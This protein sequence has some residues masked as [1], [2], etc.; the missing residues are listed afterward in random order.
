MIPRQTD[1]L[2]GTETKCDN[3]CKHLLRII[4][5]ALNEKNCNMKQNSDAGTKGA[6]IGG[7]CHDL[8]ANVQRA[9]PRMS[10]VL[11]DISVF[12]DEPQ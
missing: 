8:F 6:R 4:C 12:I 3:P 10:F 2:Q 7:I 1:T 11:D 5:R 9:Q